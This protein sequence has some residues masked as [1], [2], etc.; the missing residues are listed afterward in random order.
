M[1]RAAGVRPLAADPDEEVPPSSVS[2]EDRL[3]CDAT[4][5]IS[6]AGGKLTTYRAMAERIVDRVLRALPQQRRREAGVTRTHV[7][8]LRRD[9]FDA[10]TLTERLRSRFGVGALQAQHLVCHYGGAAETLLAEAPAELRAPIGDSRFSF[11]EIPWVWRTECPITLCDLL[12]R[13][14]RMAL[15]AR[16]QGLPELHRIAEVAAAAAGWDA[17]RC[18]A[19]ARAY[20]AS[21]QRRYQI[22]ASGSQRTAA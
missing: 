6:V 1:P 4:G 11:A 10:A 9:D 8:P 12:E 19:E 15:F 7:L 18:R 13:R 17:E 20:T 21:L 5:L 2:R 3:E 22:Q 16:G 14:M